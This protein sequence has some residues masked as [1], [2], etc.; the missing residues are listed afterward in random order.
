MSNPFEE[1][2][3]AFEEVADAMEEATED[4]PMVDDEEQVGD[5]EVA[6]LSVDVGDQPEYT[7]PSIRELAEDMD[8]ALGAL[9]DAFGSE[10]LGTEGFWAT[11]SEETGL[12]IPRGGLVPPSMET[13]EGPSPVQIISQTD[14]ST[15]VEKTPGEGQVDAVTD[16]SEVENVT[17]ERFTNT[18]SQLRS[19]DQKLDNL[20]EAQSALG[21]SQ[22]AIGTQIEALEDD[23]ST[24][25]ERLGDPDTDDELLRDAMGEIEEQMQAGVELIEE[26]D[27]KIEA[28]QERGESLLSDRNEYRGEVKALYK[29]AKASDRPALLDDLTTAYRGY[30]LRSPMDVPFRPQVVTH[31]LSR[32]KTYR[33]RGQLPA[34]PERLIED[35]TG[36]WEHQPEE[37]EAGIGLL[38]VTGEL[39]VTDSGLKFSELTGGP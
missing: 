29:A 9:E 32:M 4:S 33:S 36:V 27:Q 30:R 14:P 37:V 31:I 34:D 24:V 18:L 39:W 17:E 23:M 5:P 1:V 26:A 21:T 10:I 22:G 20:D 19:L 38:T 28:I 15:I 11:F 16:P 35:V 13:D 2:A 6:D 3:E 7:Y 12:D 8:M 25:E